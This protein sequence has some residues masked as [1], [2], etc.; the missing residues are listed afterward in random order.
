MDIA[1]IAAL[2]LVASAVGTLTGFGTSTI[3]VPV[4][5]SLL[6]VPQVL[7]LVGINR[8]GGPGR[9]SSGNAFARHLRGRSG[10]SQRPLPTRCGNQTETLPPPRFDS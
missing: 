5:A 4:L 9:L 8:Q 1:L 10:A 2:T 6:P 3:M 7:L